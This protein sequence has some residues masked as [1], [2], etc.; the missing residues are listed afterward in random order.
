MAG[1]AGA[2]I[3]LT[4]LA[5]IVENVK[6]AQSG[7]GFLTMSNGN[8]VAINPVGEK[9]IGL[10]AAN[11]AANKGVTGLDRSLRNSTQKA[12]S[13]LPLDADGTI[14]HISLT[15]QGKRFLISWSSSNCAP[16]ISG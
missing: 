10:R 12:I 11:D 7:F 9:A 4:Q 8:V 14:Q 13:T 1:A 5:E 16:P 2:D 6:V 3:T 15:E